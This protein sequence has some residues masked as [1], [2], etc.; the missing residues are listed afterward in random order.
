MSRPHLIVHRGAPGAP[1][2]LWAR[3]KN[4]LNALL[5][6]LAAASYSLGDINATVI[7]TVIVTLAIT[8]AFAQEHRSNQAAAKLRAMVK[9][10]VRVKRQGAASAGTE[11]QSNGFRELPIEEL[12]PGDIV[13]LSAV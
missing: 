13:R 9:A 3:A 10:T 2:E 6:C 7:I 11:N 4:P 5:L 8:M 12:V 1:Q